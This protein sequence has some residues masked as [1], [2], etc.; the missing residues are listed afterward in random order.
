M[1]TQITPGA[2]SQGGGIE[3]LTEL[4]GGAFGTGSTIG[5]YKSSFVPNRLS[6]Y[7]DFDAAKADF[8]G[9]APVDVTWD[10]PGVDGNGKA[11]T[12]SQD[13][14]FQATDDVTPNTIGGVYLYTE[15]AAGPPA[16]RV[17]QNYYQFLTPV[18]LSVAL[19]FMTVKLI[20]QQ[21]DLSGIAVVV[22]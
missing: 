5:L 22:S 1:A 15:T 13:A 7:A 19:A 14:F 18:S 17:I 20:V 12:Q 3:V 16:V 10:A 4:T 6:S 11:T 9:Y 21:P 8:T 2:Q